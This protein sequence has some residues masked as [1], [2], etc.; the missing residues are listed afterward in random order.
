[1]KRILGFVLAGILLLSACGVSDTGRM[2]GEGVEVRDYWARA[3]LKDGTSAVYMLLLNHDA[4]DDA[5]VGVSSDV[6]SALELHLSKMGDDGTM[7]MIPQETIA[8]PG[9]GEVELKPGSYHIMMI[10]LV[11]DLNVGDE[12]TLTLHFQNHDDITLTVPV[13]EAANM[14]G[15]GMDGHNTM[16]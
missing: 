7:Q 6:A 16:P 2:D 3:A 14:G 15:S 5:F 1:M 4:E 8:L 10:G 13:K 12:I 11:K 9:N